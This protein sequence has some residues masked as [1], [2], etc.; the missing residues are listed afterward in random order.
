MED[1]KAGMKTKLVQRVTLLVDQLVNWTDETERPTLAQIEEIVLKLREQMGEA[2]AEAVIERQEAKRPVPGPSCPECGQEM[3]YK[4][5]KGCR[6]ISQVGELDIQ[7]GYYY[8]ERCGSGSFPLD[9][10]LG[11]KDK[12]WSESV[13]KLAVWLSG[14]VE[15]EQA[16]Q[17]LAKVGRISLSDSSIWRRC[18]EWGERFRVIERNERKLRMALPERGEVITGERP[19]AR[20]MGVAIDGATVHLREE[21][22]KEL[23]VGCVFEVERA[24][25]GEQARPAGEMPGDGPELARAVRSSYVA[26]LGGPELLGQL[27]WAEAQRRGWSQARETIALGDG[28]AWIWNVVT[29]HFYDSRQAV[30]WYHATQHLAHAGHVLYGEGSAAAQRWYRHY[31]TV[32]FQGHA[33]QIAQELSQAAQHRPHLADDLRREAGYFRKN[34][35]RMQ[36]MELREDGLPIGSG[37]VESGCKQYRAR[38]AGPGMRWS[39]TGLERLLPIRSA[40]MGNRFDLLWQAARSL[41]PN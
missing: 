35:R 4:G 15:F 24:L 32:L 22:W 23:K 14:L 26:H 37:A 2:M 19:S 39:R 33:E 3:H 34:W 13:V 6:V 10:Q 30:D 20:V 16:E 5:V 31:E 17:I 38:F 36:Y 1:T 18:Q 9:E 27:V 28:A 25:P 29:E 8:C 40:I 7:R 21:G 11:M 12:H 41:P